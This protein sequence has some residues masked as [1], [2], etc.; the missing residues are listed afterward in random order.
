MTTFFFVENSERNY[1]PYSRQF[2]QFSFLL[3][4]DR[5]GINFII[6]DIFGCFSLL[7]SSEDLREIIFII[8]NI[9]YEFL[10]CCFPAFWEEF[11]EISRWFSLLLS[12]EN[13]RRISRDFWM[14][15]F[16]LVYED[17]IVIFQLLC[18]YDFHLMSGMTLRHSKHS[19]HVASFRVEPFLVMEEN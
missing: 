10:F 3:S 9:F 5:R 8:R 2:W 17:L 12:S 1:F 18:R 4:S 19:D 7:L 15:F 14:I 6:P 16:L 13:L 11:P